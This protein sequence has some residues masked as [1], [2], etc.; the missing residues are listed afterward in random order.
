MHTGRDEKI[1]IR[2]FPNAFQIRPTF[3]AS[4]SKYIHR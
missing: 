1:S 2:F 4:N 3:A